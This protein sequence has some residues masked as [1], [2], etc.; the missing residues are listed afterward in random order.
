MMWKS[1]YRISRATRSPLYNLW[2]VRNQIYLKIPQK[3]MK[4]GAGLRIKCM[5]KANNA[6]TYNRRNFMGGRV[7]ELKIPRRAN[8]GVEFAVKN[9]NYVVLNLFRT[10]DNFQELYIF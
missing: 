9:R 1:T 6:D 4:I 2:M 5:P 10:V 7:F 8:S 3:I